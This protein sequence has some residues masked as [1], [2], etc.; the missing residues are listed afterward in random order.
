[1]NTTISIE[2][3]DSVPEDATVRHFDELTPAAQERFPALAAGVP[4]AALFDGATPTGLEDGDIVV[5]TGYYR[6]TVT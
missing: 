5:Y 6:I 3:T 4:S 2:P 1:M